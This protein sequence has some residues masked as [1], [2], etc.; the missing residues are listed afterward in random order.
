MAEFNYRAVDAQGTVTS[1]TIAAD[2]E[3]MLDARLGEFGLWVIEST[4]VQDRRRAH[5]RASVSRRELTDF[6]AA[7]T[8]LLG[9]GV[10]LAEAL[11]TMVDETENLG[12]KAVLSD[13]AHRVKAGNSLV[14]SMTA[15]PK[16]FP[17][18]MRNILEAGEF[19]GNLTNV[20]A[21]LAKHFGWVDQL[22]GQVRQASI[23]PAAVLGAV[24]AFVVLLFTF[25][26]PRFA[27]VLADMD[28]PLPL[29]TRL[30]LET[31]NVIQTAW[32]AI[33]LIPFGILIL[34]AALGKTSA[35][36]L[37]L[38]AA[39][40]KLPVFGKLQLLIVLSRL[41][42]NLSLLARSGVPL[43]QAVQLCRG[44]V[45]NE[46][47]ARALDDAQR[48]I[49]EGE[50]LSDVIR[51]HPIFPPLLL[52]MVVVGEQTGRIDATLDHLS[53]RYEEELPRTV[54]QVFGIMEPVMIIALVGI[55]GFVALSLFLPLLNLMDLMG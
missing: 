27:K 41:T 17:A 39:K 31:G 14:E 34:T 8:S 11:E 10:A 48:A 45:G 7:M 35:G 21:D 13:V 30:V 36:R 32:W 2:S 3:A 44:L 6:C 1:G 47:V 42:H 20:F 29:A 54:K 50:Q 25:V 38:D 15:Y 9:A 55:V 37:L 46:V 43:L 51:R 26:V 12:F 24:I 22:I 33:V 53:H 23:Y 49:S 40:L 5:N 4:Q 16:V 19:S 28:A 52:R 18:Q